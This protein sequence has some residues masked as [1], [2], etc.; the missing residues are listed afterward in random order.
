MVAVLLS[1][2]IVI[3]FILRKRVRRVFGTIESG[4][5]KIRAG[6]YDYYIPE[7]KYVDMDVI[8]SLPNDMSRNIEGKSKQLFNLNAGLEA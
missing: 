2:I 5:E 6:H 4:M 8:I 1:N 7:S 3:L